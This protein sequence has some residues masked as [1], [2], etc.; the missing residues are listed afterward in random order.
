[1][2]DSTGS[3]IICNANYYPVNGICSSCIGPI[4]NYNIYDNTGACTNCNTNY[5]VISTGTCSCIEGTTNCNVCDYPVSGICKT[6][7]GGTTSLPVIIMVLVLIAQ[8]ITM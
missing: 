1:M 3:C 4:T 8:Q 5:Y 6:C 2:C 7:I